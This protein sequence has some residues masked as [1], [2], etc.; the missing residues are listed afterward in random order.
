MAR[1]ICALRRSPH[2]GGQ[3][4]QQCGFMLQF[5]KLEGLYRRYKDNG[6]M[7]VGFPSNDFRQELVTN[8][9]IGE[10]CLLTYRVQFPMVEKSS[11]TGASADPLYRQLLAATGQPPKWNFHKY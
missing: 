10:F 7:V 11:V 9:E 1:S 5:E 2:A 4:G 8:K 3:H 6:L